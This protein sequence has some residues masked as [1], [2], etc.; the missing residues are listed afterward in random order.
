MGKHLQ[1]SAAAATYQP[2]DSDLTAI[3]AITT[4]GFLIRAAGAWTVDTNTYLTTAAAAA[5]YAPISHTH[6]IA[7]VTGLQTALDGKQPLDADLTAIAGLA[8]NTGLLKKTAANTWTL[9]TSTYLTGNQTISLSGDVS[10]SGSTSIS[11]T[12]ANSGV[13]AGSYGSASSVATYTVDAKG[14]LTAANSTAIAIAQSQVT[15]LTTDLAAKVAK[16]GDTMTGKLTAAT[17]SAA[18]ASLRIP[19]GTVSPSSPADGDM[20]GTSGG[21]WYRNGTVTRRV[22]RVSVASTAPASPI[23]GDIWVDTST[24]AW[25]AMTL[26]GSTTW[27]DYGSPFAPPGYLKNSA[28]YVSLRGLVRYGVGTICVLPVGYRPAGTMIFIAM[29]MTGIADLRIDVN[30]NVV[31]SNYYNGGSNGWVSLSGIGFQTV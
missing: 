28:G 3:A 5:A 4:N 13:T 17:V 9:D 26:T 18:G 6:T 10:G 14:R 7:N 8:T 11:A 23:D 19:P 27:Q 22:P 16:A 1:E 20:W 21:I 31:V 30:G 24:P 2:L 15:N 29:S 25:I 12:L